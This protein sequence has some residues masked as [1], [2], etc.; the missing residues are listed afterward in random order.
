MSI[1]DL[2]SNINPAYL[3]GIVSLAAFLLGGGVVNFIWSQRNRARSSSSKGKQREEARRRQTIA[4]V[5]AQQLDANRMREVYQLLSNLTSTLNYQRVLEAALD[6][7][8]KALATSNI[9]EDR[10]VGSVLLFSSGN[11]GDPDLYFGASRRLTPADLKQT[12]PAQ[13]GILKE[14]VD[15]GGAIFAQNPSQDPE[16]GRIMALQGCASLYCIPLRQGIDTYGVMF[17]AHPQADFFHPTHREVL[18]IIAKQAVISIQNARL[19][20]DLSLEKERMTEI[21]EEGRKK[22]ARD[23]HD[24]PTQS[25]AAIAMRVNFARRLMERDQGAAADELFKI[26]DLARRTTKEIRHMLFTLRPLVLETQGLSAA[27]DAM[28]EKMYES[29]KQTVIPKLDPEIVDQFEMDKQGIIF[30]II[31]EAVNNARKHAEAEHIYVRLRPIQEDLALLEIQDDGQGF[32]VKLVTASYEHRGS[33]GML[34]LR[35]RTELVNGVIN[36]DS[37]PGV[38]TQIQVAIPL[39]EEAVD[40]IRHSV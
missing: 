11:D 30:Y 13:R 33:L 35:E 9:P 17:F 1:P 36:I 2:L 31:E 5:K 3:A 16:L 18:N 20:Q 24:G 19:Y 14:V 6:M 10:L 32:D 21:Q 28:A 39:T 27:V 34:N 22:L 15:E 25:I 8:L 29:Y 23:L 37:T 12:F 4:K 40:R 26:E 7:G 38:G